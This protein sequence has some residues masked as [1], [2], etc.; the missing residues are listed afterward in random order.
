MTG[1]K[2]VFELKI[3]DLP[4]R[5]SRLCA[6]CRPPD[7]LLL[8]DRFKDWLAFKYLA[9]NLGPELQKLLYSIIQLL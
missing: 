7:M 6:Q 1:K 2:A 9:D 3:A 4:N 8:K 5:I